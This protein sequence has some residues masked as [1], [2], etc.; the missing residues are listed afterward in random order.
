MRASGTVPGDVPVA[1]GSDPL[2]SASGLRHA[3]LR[4]VGLVERVLQGVVDV[5]VLL[6]LL[7]VPW[8]LG[9]VAAVTTGSGTALTLLACTTAS[10]V[11]LLAVVV[12]WPARDGGRT[13]G[14][15]WAGLRVVD[16]RG[17]PAG[18]AACTVRALVVPADL[19][20]GAPL[21]LAR[22]DRRRL[23]DLL[24]GTQVVRDTLPA[25]RPLRRGSPV[26][27]AAAARARR[28]GTATSPRAGSR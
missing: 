23:G 11:V 4:P 3:V 13:P 18:L 19:V 26:V 14:M 12:V 20:V 24:A 25:P 22:E 6:L 8:L 21:V 2:G 9:L 7:S 16:R 10:V 27:S 15:R 28:P 1:P 17:R 5:L